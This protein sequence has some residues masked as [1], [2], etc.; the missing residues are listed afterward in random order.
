MQRGFEEAEL[1]IV[2]AVYDNCLSGTGREIGCAYLR[3]IYELTFVALY[4]SYG[5]KYYPL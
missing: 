5:T 2:G 1:A 3:V 4:G